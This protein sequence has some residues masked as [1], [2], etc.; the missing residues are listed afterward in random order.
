MILT[1]STLE[2]QLFSGRWT[3]S[4]VAEKKADSGEAR[5]ALTQFDRENYSRTLVTTPEPTVLP[6]SRMANRLPSC[7]AMG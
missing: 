1:E 6:P 3:E 2:F 7:M 5:R 4:A